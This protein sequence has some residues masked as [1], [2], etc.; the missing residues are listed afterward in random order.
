MSQGPSPADSFLQRILQT[1][2]H[3]LLERA[4][5][6]PMTSPIV[7]IEHQNYKGY[8]R[9]MVFF[10]HIPN[11]SKHLQIA[12]GARKGDFF[13]FAMDLW[14]HW[15][16]MATQ[17]WHSQSLWWARLMIRKLPSRLM[18]FELRI[19]MGNWRWS[20]SDLPIMQ[21]SST[22]VYERLDYKD[23]IDRII[24]Q[25]TYHNHNFCAFLKKHL[26]LASK[27]IPFLCHQKQSHNPSPFKL[28]PPWQ[29]QGLALG[30]AKDTPQS[31]MDSNV[32]R[33]IQ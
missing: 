5:F 3:S 32:G 30:P 12:L 22:Q 28:D 6:K 1:H 2:L 24:I 26:A 19:Q 15:D 25:I 13:Y 11:I 8:Q 31:G 23:C 16:A 29:L 20:K 21:S 4:T 7:E 18:V 33:K 14:M 9:I 17:S 10:Q 27:G